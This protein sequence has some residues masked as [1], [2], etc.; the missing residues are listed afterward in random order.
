MNLGLLIQRIH[1][2]FK[3]QAVDKGLDFTYQY[4]DTLPKT[5][6][7]D[8]TKITQI[9]NNLLSN[10]IKFTPERKRI[11]LIVENMGATMRI[12]VADQGLG[13][14]I[15]KQALIF[16][17]FEQADT[18]TTR[19]HGGT[20]LGLAICK[21]LS[22]T[23]GGR[24]W[25]DSTEGKGTTFYVELPIQPIDRDIEE[26]RGGA[27]IEVGAARESTILVVEDNPMNQAVML[28]MFREL[29]IEVVM[30][31]DGQAGVQ[32]ALEEEPDCIFMDLHMPRMDGL[33]ATRQ[34]RELPQ[35]ADVPII[36]LSADAFTEQKQIAYE[37]GVTDYLTKPILLDKLVAKLRQ[38][39]Q[40]EPAPPAEKVPKQLLDRE[41]LRQYPESLLVRLI[42]MF[43]TMVP[44]SMAKLRDHYRDRNSKQ[45][46]QEAHTLR[47]CGIGVFAT[48]FVAVST[49]LEIASERKEWG[50]IGELIPRV[51]GAYETAMDALD[52]LSPS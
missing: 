26:E 37:A 5:I 31:N 17:A 52:A 21:R 34:L 11:D 4:D 8:R 27:E 6:L 24:I 42:E 49:E 38:Y 3:L 45:L 33:E 46:F 36:A 29:G 14:P 10:A 25:L 40:S 41:R 13:I 35:F 32:T 30:A 15:A 1:N 18:S 20:G 43:R 19:S 48:H 50:A 16:E 28:S 39:L 9:L 44:E 22:E 2:R 51:E 12:V 7:S 47:N 23:L